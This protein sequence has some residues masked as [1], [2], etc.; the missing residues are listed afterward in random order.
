MASRKRYYKTSEVLEELL[1]QSDSDVC[2]S[3]SEKTE[4]SSDLSHPDESE[5]ETDDDPDAP[6]LAHTRVLPALL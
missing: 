6:L 3:D 5:S 1:G 4:D 2:E